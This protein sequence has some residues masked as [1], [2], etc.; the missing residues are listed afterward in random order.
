MSDWSWRAGVALGQLAGTGRPF[1]A[2]DLRK[3]IGPPPGPGAMGAAFQSAVWAGVIQP[4][5]RAASKTRSRNGG[6]L[7]VW[8]AA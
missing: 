3:A 5:G 8:A 6:G 1:T 4:V 2:D 7:K